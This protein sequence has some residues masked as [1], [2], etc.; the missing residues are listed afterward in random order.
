MPEKYTKE[1]ETTE[2]SFE[3]DLAYNMLLYP[4]FNDIL[5]RVYQEHVFFVTYDTKGLAYKDYMLKFND[6][7]EQDA[8]HVNDFIKKHGV[9]KVELYLLKVNDKLRI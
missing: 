2:L 3:E 4:D 7:R 9:R 1:P 5:H 6:R 8:I